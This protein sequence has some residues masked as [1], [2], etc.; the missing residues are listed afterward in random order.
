MKSSISTINLTHV[1]GAVV[2]TCVMLMSVLVPSQKAQAQT[3]EDLQEI[4]AQLLAQVAALQAQL[5]ELQGNEGNEGEPSEGGEGPGVEVEER[6][7]VELTY[8]LYRGMSDRRTNGEVSKLQ[9]FLAE[10][11]DYTYPRITG[12]Y[13]ES[14][15]TA[16]KK[17][18]ARNGVVS[19]GT[20]R[21]TGY[22]VVGEKTR[23]AMAKGCVPPISDPYPPTPTIE[24]TSPNGGEEWKTRQVNT[25]TWKPYSYDPDINPADDVT[26]Y[27]EKR[28]RGRYQTVG[29]IMENGKASIHTHLEIDRYGNYADSGD[30]YVRV[31]N[32]ETGEW[33]RSDRSFEIINEDPEEDE[34]R[35]LS[36][37]GGETIKIGEKYRI[38]WSGPQDGEY[39]LNVQDADGYGVGL[40][41]KGTVDGNENSWK[42]GNV[43]I[44]SDR[45]WVTETLEPGSYKI[46]INEISTGYGISDESNRTFELVGDVEEEKEF[47]VEVLSPNGGEEIDPSEPVRIA[48]TATN[49]DTVS[50]ALYKSDRWLAWIHRDLD[51]GLDGKQAISWTPTE[52]IIEKAG[53]DENLKIYITGRRDDGN[54]YVD[55]KSDRPFAFESTST[56]ENQYLSVTASDDSVQSGE[57]VTYTIKKKN[58]FVR[59]AKIETRCDDDLVSINAKGGSS[60]GEDTIVRFRGD[61]YA[62]TE[63]YDAVRNADVV[64]TA[65]PLNWLKRTLP[66]PVPSVEVAVTG[67]GVSTDNL[68]LETSGLDPDAATLLLD[69]NDTTEYAIFAFELSAEGS[70][71]E[72]TIDEIMVEV[73][74]SADSLNT[75]VRDFRLH[76]SGDVLSA[77]YPA[78]SYDGSDNDAQLVFDIS[79]TIVINPEE[80]VDF[81]LFVEFDS[82]ESVPSEGYTIGASI[83]PS[84]VDAE[85]A[86]GDVSL[87]GRQVK[88]ATHTIRGGSAQLLLDSE[89]SDGTGTADSVVIVGETT[90]DNYATM[91]LEFDITALNDDLWVPMDSIT[92]GN[93]NTAGV[94]LDILL[95]GIVTN[96]GTLQ[97][98]YDIEGADEDNGY[99]EL[100]EGESYT[101]VV[102]VEMFKPTQT[103]SYSFR[104]NSIGYNDREYAAPNKTAVPEDRDEY[105]SDSVSVPSGG[106]SQASYGGGYS[107]SGYYSQT[108]YYG[109]G[110][111]GGVRGAA[112]SISSEV[113]QELLSALKRTYDN[114]GGYRTQ[115]QS[116]MRGEVL[117]ASISNEEIMK[118]IQELLKILLQLQA[119]L[120]EMVAANDTE[121]VTVDSE[122]EVYENNEN[123]FRIE[124]PTGGETI[125]ASAI[126]K[127]TW[128]PLYPVHKVRAYLETKRS[129]GFKTVG[130]IEPLE[131]LGDDAI[132]WAGNMALRN[133]DIPTMNRDYYIRIEN[134]ETGES[135]RTKSAFTI[136]DP[137]SYLEV[138]VVKVNGSGF[139]DSYS[140][141]PSKQIPS[142]ATEVSI[143]WESNRHSEECTIYLS[144][145]NKRVN[146]V[147]AEGLDTKG[148]IT[149]QLPKA[150]VGDRILVNVSCVS[151]G[152]V[153]ERNHGEGNAYLLK[154]SERAESPD[155]TESDTG[156]DTVEVGVNV[157]KLETD[158]RENDEYSTDDNEAVLT[159]T[160]EVGALTDAYLEDTATVLEGTVPD[161]KDGIFVTVFDQGGKSV[162]P[163]VVKDI[164]IS[165]SAERVDG[166]YVTPRGHSSSF[167]LTMVIDPDEAGYY[168]G[169]LSA[170]RFTSQPGRGASD[171]VVVDGGQTDNIFVN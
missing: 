148:T 66:G 49:I 82:L 137:D 31:V 131:N 98:S 38:K 146:N 15:E 110:A 142:S 55:D 107:Q 153:Y 135:S 6:Q 158:V 164:T 91:F 143:S 170:L 88:G 3:T 73:D 57:Q 37:N 85:G 96:T 20:P 132:Y 50:I 150:S 11:G 162:S 100:N 86:Q 23:E 124:S 168:S 18:Q 125:E 117:G 145:I 75:L 2:V 16:V 161:S 27:L 127:I 105:T 71:N 83:G 48:W 17:W 104:L 40:A 32:N 53:T 46:H 77:T 147:K 7:C 134:T 149:M 51:N 68:T 165:S 74:T 138:D 108:S 62:W 95:G 47:S 9:R 79:E 119:Q 157:V 80:T 43:Y 122:V 67:V 136:A 60:C 21:S 116:E 25:I 52:E 4:I 155:T 94:A 1:I 163:S 24:V 34:V 121:D 126:R 30:Y 106:Y 70:E 115:L 140:G 81:E 41:E 113:R 93:A 129:T 123:D 42:A 22:G 69:E 169:E 167:T 97:A 120:A 156:N 8:T 133:G 28:V 45:G 152:A 35:V 29:K 13:G 61:M 59:Y 144:N 128:S 171:L 26:A 109:Q 72:I 58:G 64:F 166:Y 103:G 33:D 89:P 154:G 14:T 87:G 65:T 92:R 44:Q 10:T 139:D 151:A 111:Y 101:M 12:Y 56:S 99:F 130:E 76:A 39:V 78:E 118:Q 114:L 19:Y 159:F 84:M 102:T 160:F 54:G 141:H 63:S 112:T 5:A 90:N 36:P